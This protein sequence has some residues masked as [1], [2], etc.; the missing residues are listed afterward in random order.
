MVSSLATRFTVVGWD[1]VQGARD[2]FTNAEVTLASSLEAALSDADVVVSML[3]DGDD[4]A[5]VYGKSV[6]GGVRPLT[7]KP[8]CGLPNSPLP[9]G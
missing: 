7:W 1:V 9:V 3:P 8:P 2:A 5:T 4:V 6:L